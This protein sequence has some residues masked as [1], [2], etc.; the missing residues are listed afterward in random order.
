MEQRENRYQELTRYI[1]LEV[2]DLAVLDEL[3]RMLRSD[4][5]ALADAFYERTRQHPTLHALFRDDAQITRLKTSLVHWMEEFFFAARDERYWEGRARVGRI[6]IS[7]G[8]PQRFLVAAM[9][10]FREMFAA[11][12]AELRDPLAAAS[13]LH[14]AVDLELGVILEGYRVV[15]E[16]RLEKLETISDQGLIPEAKHY[17][18]AVELAPLIIIGLDVEGRIRLFSP[19]AERVTGLKLDEVLGQPFVDVLMPEYARDE[20]REIIRHAVPLESRGMAWE[21]DLLARSGRL[22]RV[23]LQ[24]SEIGHEEVAFFAIGRDVTEE[25][26]RQKRLAQTERLAAVG[27]LAAGLAHEIRNPLNGALLHVTFLERALAKN[28]IGPEA[29]D[30][31]R[32]VGDEVRRLSALVRDFLVFARPSASKIAP[33][34]VSRLVQ[35]VVELL[36]SEALAARTELRV[37][38]PSSEIVVDLDEAKIKQALLNLGRNAIES[39]ATQDGGTIVFRTRREPW[40]VFIEVEDDGPG[41]PSPDAPIFDAFFTTKANGTGLGLAIAHRAV[42]DHGGAIDVSSRPGQTIFRMTLPMDRMEAA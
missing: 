16:D 26:V 6:H 32:L 34:S 9:S 22:K 12:C 7:V 20:A 37:D 18:R 28:P 2:S 1:G 14:R 36:A 25:R 39:L 19:E 33:V 35:R 8:L 29:E 17:I 42:T 3:G 10:Q 15:Y 21:T 31:V 40:R 4:F 38:G 13:V 23:A 41:L 27:T 11:R 24:V 30:A 5:A